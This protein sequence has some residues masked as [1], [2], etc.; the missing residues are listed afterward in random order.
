MSVFDRFRPAPSVG[1]VD[2]RRVT[3]RSAVAVGTDG[4][5]R[6]LTEFHEAIDYVR[7]DHLAA[8]VRDAKARWQ[9]VEVSDEP[10]AGPG[11]YHGQTFVPP[12]LLVPDAGTVY[13]AER[14][15]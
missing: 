10:D 7:P 9:H 6:I 11:G 13:P 3:M 1:V 4:R 2:K 15:T 5:G 12:D 8:Y 14:P